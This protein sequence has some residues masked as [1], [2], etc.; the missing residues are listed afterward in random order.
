MTPPPPP[1]IDD[2]TLSRLLDGRWPADE[3]DA[4]RHRLASD[5]AAAERL[6]RWTRQHE[7]LSRLHAEQDLGAAPAAMV[8]AAQAL[9]QRHHAVRRMSL[10]G[11]M[12]AS[13][14]L[15]FGVGWIAH[16]QWSTNQAPSARW[17]GGFVRDAVVAHAVYL[18]EVRHPVEVG[19]DQQAH[20]VQW[21]SRRLGRPLKLPHLGAQGFELVGGR[22][23]PG[24][25][26]AR[27]QFMYQD[28][29]GTRLTLYLGALRQDAA[30]AR[31][32]ETAFQ[33]TERDGIASFYWVDQGFGYAMNGTIGRARLLQIARAVHEQL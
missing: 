32:A 33:F 21:L 11:G 19:A 26:G 4:L 18:P 15:A 10:L 8:R 22:L 5:P 31:T 20:L 30:G 12:A 29:S 2:E 23:L 17:A 13:L 9:A 24:E 25:D 28:A 7:R 3:A 6:A 1:S 14:T 16:A 27:A